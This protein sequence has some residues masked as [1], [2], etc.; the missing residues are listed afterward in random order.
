M[1]C[2]VGSTNTCKAVIF[3]EHLIFASSVKSRN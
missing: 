3:R 1:Y 2:C